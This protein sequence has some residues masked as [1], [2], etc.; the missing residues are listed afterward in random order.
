MSARPGAF[1]NPG[2]RS[3][4]RP[5]DAERDVRRSARACRLPGRHRRR[6]ARRPARPARDVVQVDAV[7]GVGTI[8]QTG[9]Y[10]DMVVGL[11]RRQVPRRRRSTPTTTRSRS[12]QASTAR[13]SSSSSRACRS[14]GRWSARPPPRTPTP[15]PGAAGAATPSVGDADGHR[16]E[17]ALVILSVTAQQAELIKFA[18]I[19]G[20]SRSSSAHRRTSSTRTASRCCRPPPGTTGVILKT[21]VDGGYGV[22]RPELVE[23]IIPAQ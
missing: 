13:A 14:S 21:L 3:S 22:L 2:L 5:F 17:H 1:Q 15:P 18:Q 8:I 6:Q 9:D 19:E 20:R 12:S 7:N 10:V 16:S 11:Y 23:A 4:A